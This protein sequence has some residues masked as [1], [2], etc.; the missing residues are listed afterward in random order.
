[1]SKKCDLTGARPKSGFSVSHS[2]K[3][4]KRR[5][6]PNLQKKRVYV[7]EEGRWV[8]LRLT[9][10]AIRTLSKKGTGILSKRRSG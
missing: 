1:M 9:A 4:V 2:K 5:W 8:T 10:A 6:V 7:A 3:A